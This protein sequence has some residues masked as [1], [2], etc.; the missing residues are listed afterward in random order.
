MNHT[1][2]D[3][4]LN[5]L[6]DITILQSTKEQIADLGE[7]IKDNLGLKFNFFSQQ[8]NYDYFNEYYL[9][10]LKIICIITF[11]L[12]VVI[13]CLSVWN[14]LVS[15]R[16]MLKEFTINLLVGL[17][18][19]KLKKIFYGYFGILS[20]INLIVILIGVIVVE[21]MLWKIKKIPISLGCYNDKNY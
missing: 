9:H 2:I 5:G 17:S 1:N 13:T 14:A 19:S 16:L 15:V 21:S 8:E 7:V 12:L 6:M 10:T 11:I 20:F 18:Y 3:L 4:R